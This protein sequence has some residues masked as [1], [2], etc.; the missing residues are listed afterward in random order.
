MLIDRIIVVDKLYVLFDTY[1]PI[2]LVFY[3]FLYKI[4][5]IYGIRMI[6]REN[7]D[8]TTSSK[9]FIR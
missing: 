8:V 9:E 7:K 2:V 3:F 1:A 5:L 6:T 4:E